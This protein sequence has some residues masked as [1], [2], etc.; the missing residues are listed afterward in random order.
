M[1]IRKTKSKFIRL[2]CGCGNEQNVFGSGSSKIRCLV[3]NADLAIPTGGR[4]R[5][6][7]EKVKMVKALD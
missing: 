7:D 5:L 1:A 4:I 6:A 2:K 3:C